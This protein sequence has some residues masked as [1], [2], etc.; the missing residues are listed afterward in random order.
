LNSAKIEAAVEVTRFVLRL[1]MDEFD[2]DPLQ[3]TKAFDGLDEL[4]RDELVSRGFVTELS[5]FCFRAPTERLKAAAAA[6][7]D[8]AQDQAVKVFSTDSSRHLPR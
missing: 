4:T 1:A 8:A 2:S 6:V 7:L 3:F 5:E